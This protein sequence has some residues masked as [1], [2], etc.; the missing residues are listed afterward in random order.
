MAKKAIPLEK[1][2]GDCD[3]WWPSTPVPLEKQG[4]CRFSN[5]PQKKS[6]YDKACGNLSE[7]NEFGGNL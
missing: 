3:S 6:R 4:L 1:T 7:Q 2:C 5:P